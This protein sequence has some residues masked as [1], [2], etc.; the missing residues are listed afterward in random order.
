[1]EE[2]E[3][4]FNSNT[5]MVL[6][7]ASENLSGSRG[8]GRIPVRSV[9]ELAHRRGTP[10]LVDAAPELP[11]VS[12]LTY[13]TRLGAD[14]V[15]FSGGKGLMGPQCSGM[16]VGR[17]DLVEAACLNHMAGSDTIG[18]Q[19]KVGKEEI[20]SYG[21]LSSSLVSTTKKRNA[22]GPPGYSNA[23]RGSCQAFVPLKRILCRRISSLR[24]SR[25]YM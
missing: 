23:S 7:L 1:M 4:A 2:Y 13:F 22:G 15:C 11:P 12:N 10:V 3:Q 18:R 25:G 20:G 6:H 16:L 24:T 5:A 14:L 21:R 9:I 8:P 19:M 17:R